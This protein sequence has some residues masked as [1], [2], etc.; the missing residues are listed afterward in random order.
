[1]DAKNKVGLRAQIACLYPTILQELQMA[2]RQKKPKQPEW[3]LNPPT[4]LQGKV[5]LLQETAGMY[6]MDSEE[7]IV[8]GKLMRQIETILAEAEQAQR[9]ACPP[10]F[11]IPSYEQAL[12]LNAWMYGIDF[13]CIYASNRIGKTTVEIMNWILWAFPNDPSWAIF[14]P[15]TDEHG[16]HVEVKVRP[17]FRTV[18]VIRDLARKFCYV[19]NPEEPPTYK[20]NEA[21]LANV[22]KHD[23]LMFDSAFPRPPWD[24]SGTLWVGA[25]DSSHHEQI[26]MP[27]WMKYLP[28]SCIDRHSFQMKEIT[29]VVKPTEGK[30][31][32][33]EWIGKSYESKDSKWSSGAADAIILT[34]G[35]QLKTFKEICLR[36]AEP[37]FGGH[38]FTPTEAA[39]TG[40][41]SALAMAIHKRTNPEQMWPKN[42][43]SFSGFKVQL[44]PEHI[45]PTEKRNKMVEQW[46]NSEEGK[47]RLSGEFYTSSGLIVSSLDKDRHMIPLTLKQLLEKY[48]EGKLY[49]SVDPGIDHPTACAWALLNKFNQWF[50]YRIWARRGL[51]V[52]E[53]VKEIIKK[54]GNIIEKSS[55][56]ENLRVEVLHNENSER[57]EATIMDYHAFATDENSG[58]SKSLNYLVAGLQ[59]MQSTTLG[60]EDRVDNLNE[61]LQAN[62][63]LPSVT[64]K[65]FETNTGCRL[66]FLKDGEGI[67][68][69][70]TLWSNLYWETYR[71]GPAKGLPKEQVPNHFDDELDAVCYLPCSGIVWTPVSRF[72]SIIGL[73]YKESEFNED[74]EDYGEQD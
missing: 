4:D 72:D 36:F 74:Q 66:Y 23:P 22:A 51:T 53:R 47:A 8:L 12:V 25:P 3:V 43:H 30:E 18:N 52:G 40:E 26:I 46:S 68:E 49:R 32:I 70:L 45:L 58:M 71:N 19:A 1:M 56:N 62:K 50:V 57:I 60:P 17:P 34:E 64:P 6:S 61:A 15:Y 11:F 14:T 28:E 55:D 69:T 41:S 65:D 59:V 37:S 44:A 54:S 5:E 31:V 42:Y 9:K 7:G 38:D 21:F 16:R 67:K 35:V 39:N 33:W 2:K 13:I 10:A 29:I 73:G 20:T 27:L 24:K 63:F 48:P